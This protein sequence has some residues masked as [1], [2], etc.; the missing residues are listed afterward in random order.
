MAPGATF[1]FH[2]WPSV[3]FPGSLF[4]SG[5]TEKP[6]F[7]HVLQDPEKE[8]DIKRRAWQSTPRQRLTLAVVCRLIHSLADPTWVFPGRQTYCVS[9]SPVGSR[10][11]SDTDALHYWS[12]WL[13][14]IL[15]SYY[16]F[17]AGVLMGSVVSSGTTLERASLLHPLG[18]SKHYWAEQKLR[19][20]GGGGKFFPSCKLALLER[21]AN[22]RMRLKIVIAP[23]ETKV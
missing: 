21:S 1:P 3:L 17:T 13:L 20:G 16:W 23:T 4:V 8:T 14:L 5:T 6:Q 15:P 18:K 22:K 2:R 7:L 9:I 19:G 12:G 11:W 10:L